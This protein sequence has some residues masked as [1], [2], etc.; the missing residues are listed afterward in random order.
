MYLLLLVLPSLAG[1][2]LRY[3]WKLHTISF[4][5]YFITTQQSFC[6]IIQK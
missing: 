4:Y 2:D 1:L 5:L 6:E 3:M